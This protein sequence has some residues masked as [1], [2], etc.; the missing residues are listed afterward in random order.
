MYKIN[1]IFNNFKIFQNA[2]LL[3]EKSSAQTLVS[4]IYINMTSKN[5]VCF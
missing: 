2:N 4:Y 1:D 3:S 5:L